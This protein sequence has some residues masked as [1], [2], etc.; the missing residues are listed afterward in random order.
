[1]ASKEIL[2]DLTLILKYSMFNL[3]SITSKPSLTHSLIWCFV[4]RDRGRTQW[5]LFH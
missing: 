4:W 1:L 3:L 2:E 5:R